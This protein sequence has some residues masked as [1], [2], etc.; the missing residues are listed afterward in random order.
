MLP[1]EKSGLR[2]SQSFE[3]ILE[4]SQMKRAFQEL[5]N[6]LFSLFV[7]LTPYI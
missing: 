1:K 4:L 3:E 5:Q 6:G 7:S 2:A